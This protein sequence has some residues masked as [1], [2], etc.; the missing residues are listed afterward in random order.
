M[1]QRFIH[2]PLVCKP[3][4]CPVLQDTHLGWPELGLPSGYR[5][6][7][8]LTSVAPTPLLLTGVEEYLASHPLTPESLDEAAH[9]AADSC[10]PIDDVRGSARYRKQMVKNLTAQALRE[11]LQK[12]GK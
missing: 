10:S 9:L 4:G 6:R 8:A 7:I 3:D 1:L 11:V 5:L 12:L 2:Q